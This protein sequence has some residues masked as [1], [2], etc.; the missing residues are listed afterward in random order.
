MT[1]QALNFLWLNLDLP[2]VSDPEDGSIREPLP[3][4]YIESVRK[5]GEANPHTD[6]C[7]WVDSLR[8]TER[9]LM[10][11]QEALEEGRTNVHLKDLRSI[12]SYRREKL[13]NEPETNPNWRS[14]IGRAHV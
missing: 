5:A 4:K 10:F 6:V 9:Q 13:Y 2:A 11:L 8:L 14:E 3:L 7:L 12:P 1:S